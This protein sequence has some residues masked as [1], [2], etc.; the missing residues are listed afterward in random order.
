MR[1]FKFGGASVK[2]ADGVRNVYEIVKTGLDK[3]L[4]IV[5]SAM[6][7][8]TNS[9]ESIARSSF[10][11]REYEIHLE[12][13]LQFHYDIC[14]EL[15]GDT[16]EEVKNWSV[17][18]DETL[19]TP[20][21]NWVQFYDQVI[22]FGELMSTSIVYHYLREHLSCEWLDARTCVKTNSFFTEANVDWQLTEHFIKRD[23][24]K[25]LQTGPVITQGFIGSDL[26]G[27][28]TTLGREGSDYTGAVFA[29][30]L[31]AESLTVWKDVPGLLNA[32]P[33]V[34]PEAELFDELS[35]Q[36]VTE[37]TFYGAK[38]IHP[39]TIRPL[40]QRNI[41]LLVKSFISPEGVGTKIYDHEKIATKH[42]F[43]FKENQLVVT[44]RVKDN[45]FMDEKK[46]VK[47]FQAMTHV[48]IK[49]NLMHNSALTF[50]FCMDHIADK[51][52]SLKGYL[53]NDFQVLYNEGLHLA[54]IKNF[55]Q[56]SFALL[57]HMGE[58]ILE[59]K[60]RNNYQVLYRPIETG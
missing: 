19:K 31:N 57:P 56:E 37:L 22:P 45:S 33:K 34:M 23:V 18:L 17:Q 47:V 24:Q 25:L 58:I 39:K 21:K 12:Q 51:L 50:T 8:V 4:V 20:G 29:Y 40:A 14:K 42:C 48:N 5:V 46:L 28:T 35:F 11:H 55:Q 44:L 41:P 2:D 36:E 16:P 15:F 7:K 26:T 49:I 9:L 27:K 1:I 38:V 6:G 54:T 10:D 59:Q 32:D 53:A 52:E 13:I 43:V 30:C 60:T 3:P